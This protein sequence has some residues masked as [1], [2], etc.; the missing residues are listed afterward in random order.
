MN[1]SYGLFETYFNLIDS[2][3]TAKQSEIIDINEIIKWAT[4]FI[5]SFSNWN[6]N[7]EKYRKVCDLFLKLNSRE[8]FKERLFNTL[9]GEI[10]VRVLL[11]GGE[12]NLLMLNDSS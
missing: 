11:E 6:Y 9:E 2:I 4:K 1:E 12:K 10:L 8:I 5:S 3:I 7:V